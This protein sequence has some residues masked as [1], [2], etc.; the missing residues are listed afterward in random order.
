[1]VIACGPGGFGET[2]ITTTT[3]APSTT[4]TVALPVYTVDDPTLTP[5]A[6]MTGSEGPADRAV[7]RGE[8][9]QATGFGMDM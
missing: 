6:P 3:A 5:P 1:M 4:T 2:T 9:L 7:P 8:V